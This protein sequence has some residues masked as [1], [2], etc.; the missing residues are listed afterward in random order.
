VRADASRNEARILDAARRLVGERGARAVTIA[1]VA[2]EAGVGNATVIRRFGDKAGLIAALLGGQERRL[3]EQIIR[4]RPPLG[5]GAPPL[6][7]IDAFLAALA[8]L[9]ASKLELVYASETASPGARYRIGAYR[10]WQQ[11]LALLAR[12]ARPD[13]DAELV[14]HVLLAPLAAESLAA[15]PRPRELVPML[16]ACARGMLSVK[17]GRSATRQAASRGPRAC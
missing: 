4:G 5:P 11:H 8:R 17:H 3:Q 2:T 10:A 16:Q 12:E 15:L 14:A 1:Q 13:L 7:R 6:A 9:Y